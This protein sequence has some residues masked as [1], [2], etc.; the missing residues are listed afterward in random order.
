MPRLVLLWLSAGFL[1]GIIIAGEV[2]DV[3]FLRQLGI[4]I[5][6]GL[7]CAI[8]FKN[9]KHQK[10]FFL[11]LLVVSFLLGMLRYQVEEIGLRSGN[12]ALPYSENRMVTMQG[13]VQEPTSEYIDYSETKLK[14]TQYRDENGIWQPS[15]AILLM[16]LPASFHFEYHTQVT[17]EGKISPTIK[18][19]EKPHTVWLKR[20]RID[21]QIFY[22]TIFSSVPASNTSFMSFL[23]EFKTRAYHLLQTLM[24]FPESELIAGIV[25]G[26]ES[27]IPAY[28]QNAYR[29]TGTTHIIAISGFNITLLAASVSLL[30][31]R[32]FPYRIGAL[33]SI[34]VIALYTLLVGAQPAVLRAAI[35]GILA[36]PAT[37]IGRRV[38]G[39]HALAIAAA[40]MAVENP[41]IL[42]DIGFQLS[43][44]ATF[45]ILTYIDPLTEK[46]DHFL[47]RVAA[48]SREWLLGIIKENVLTTLSAQIATLP[49]L[50]KQFG[51]LPLIAPLVNMLI[52]PLQPLL[53]EVG[54]IAVLLSMFCYPLGR[55]AGL[56]AWIPAAFNDQII[57][58]FAQI[59]S[60]LT[61]NGNGW[62]WSSIALNLFI[63]LRIVQER[64]KK[65]HKR[66]YRLI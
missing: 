66:A 32:I 3:F 21:Y 49:I 52:L 63:L 30:C 58:L 19:D 31:N 10:G 62:Y 65:Q 61:L 24:P 59:P 11:S 41:Y 23:Y 44:C 64:R 8:I 45:G 35:M 39:V 4:L 26:I 22:P 34:A 51:Q 37:L 55:I 25:L 14:V 42:W 47:N 48:P 20:N 18:P 60:T 28:L 50:I 16:R 46:T 57:L 1:A 5:L 2:S 7:L 40:C 27:R 33:I 9:K 6:I 17:F 38:I 12:T 56:I 43:F 36:I 29:Q 53:M 13:I 54:G 15:D